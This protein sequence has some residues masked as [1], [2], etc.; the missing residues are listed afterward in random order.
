M[1]MILMRA[2]RH[3]PPPPAHELRRQATVELSEFQTLLEKGDAN[4]EAAG[5][6]ALQLLVDAFLV[7]RQSQAD[8]FAAAHEVGKRLRSIFDC[9][10]AYDAEASAYE[11]MCPVHALHRV[12]AHSL[13]LT[14]LTTC[15]ICGAAAFECLHVAGQEYD[16]EICEPIVDRL[17]PLGGVAFTANPDFLY[18]WHQPQ[19][20]AVEDLLEAGT[21]TEAG[22]PLS[23]DHCLHCTGI[24][25]D[26]DLDPVARY[27]RLRNEARVSQR[28]GTDGT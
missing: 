18:T 28:S 26:G 14:I 11:H 24:P 21:I 3:G 9:P 8:L 19:N 6:R 10:I 23:C 7:D 25:D 1:K 12:V 16:G 5:R 22:T 2:G 17:L 20:F 4:A 15:S 27:E 13:E